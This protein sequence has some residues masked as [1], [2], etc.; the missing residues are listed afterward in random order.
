MLVVCCGMYRSGSTLQ[1]QIASAIV[2]HYC[3]GK[4]L[5]WNR[6]I[7]IESVLK[8]AQSQDCVLKVHDFTKQ[9]EQ[10]AKG[11]DVRFIYAHRDIRDVV[12]SLA[13]KNLSSFNDVINSGIIEGMLRNDLGWNRQSP[14]LVSRYSDLLQN[15]EHEISRIG[16]FLDVEMDNSF[17]KQ[18][19]DDCNIENQKKK[20]EK[21][22]SE[23]L[24]ET[25]TSKKFDP[26]SL[27]H[28]NH[29]A[30]GHI[31][32]WVDQLSHDQVAAIEGKCG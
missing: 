27:L 2:E 13:R 17:A 30:G 9:I 22:S 14:L 28:F 21:F 20:I 26:V 19:F 5:E 12:V 7:D 8:N 23:E 18:V 29:I 32:G 16:K 1:Y 10:A 25:G 15:L 4:R 6:E 3:K 24:V 31:D 11:N